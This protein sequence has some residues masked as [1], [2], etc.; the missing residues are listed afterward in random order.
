MLLPCQPAAKKRPLATR[1]LRKSTSY[2][3]L[4]VVVLLLI[5]REESRA[6][7]Q[8]RYASRIVE[9]KSG[10]IRGILQE[11]NSRHLDPVEVFRGIPY[12]APPVGDLRF[13]PPISPIPW[14]GIKLADSFGAVCPQ[15]F[16]D[17]RNDTVALLQMPLDRYQQLKRLYM[18]LTNQS[19]DCLFLNLYIPG[20]VMSHG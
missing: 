18:F 5:G 13:R 2:L 11:L 8:I 7:T 10:Q 14:D 9:T 3:V 1:S 6:A 19:E 15:H 17:I 20:S 16:P 4:I 12:A